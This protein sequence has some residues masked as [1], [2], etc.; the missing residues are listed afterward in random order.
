MLNIRPS[1]AAGFL[2]IQMTRALSAPMPSAMNRTTTACLMI[3]L[4]PT[5]KDADTVRRLPRRMKMQRPPFEVKRIV[6]TAA[7]AT[8]GIQENVEN[9]DEYR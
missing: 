6:E 2:L 7:D 9:I 5:R 1:S 4:T 8:P 3:I